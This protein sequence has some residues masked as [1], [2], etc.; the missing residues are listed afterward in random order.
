MLASPQNQRHRILA[1]RGLWD[2]KNKPNSIDALLGAW[3]EGFGIETDLRD[4]GQ[5]IVISHD[6]PAGDEIHLDELI[7]LLAGIGSSTGQTFAANIKADGLEKLLKELEWGNI[8]YFTF[9]MSF[10]TLYK[11]NQ[12]KIPTSIRISEFE[13]EDQML[14]KTFSITK[15]W[16]DSFTFDW[17][18]ESE[19]LPWSNPYAEVF[20]VSP[21]LHNRDPEQVWAWTK[22]MILEG[23][24]VKLCT[25]TPFEFEEYIND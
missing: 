10:P 23:H 14:A 16:L 12:F 4:L 18:L 19:R 15:Y 22:R 17:F 5:R 1:H 7:P 21:E 6:I 13:P 24:N 25:D 8:E 11:L 20:V 3:K 9:D 2:E